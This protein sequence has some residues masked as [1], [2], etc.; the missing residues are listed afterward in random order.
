MEEL[1]VVMTN[2]QLE[3]WEII[4]RYHKDSTQFVL[5]KHLPASLKTMN[6]NELVEK[7]CKSNL[8]AIPTEQKLA[9]YTEEEALRYFRSGYGTAVEIKCGNK[10]RNVVYHL[11][12][13]DQR[14]RQEDFDSFYLLVNLIKQNIVLK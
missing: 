5:M 11:S 13:N 12:L 9:T 3:E 8:F 4:G 6:G 2:Y 7:L 14:L 1:A 10:F